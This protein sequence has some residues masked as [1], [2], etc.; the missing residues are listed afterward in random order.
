MQ[1]INIILNLPSK[2]EMSAIKLRNFFKSENGNNNLQR[3]VQH[4]LNVAKDKMCVHI[5]LNI[6]NV[7]EY[8]VIQQFSNISPRNGKYD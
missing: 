8:P 7:I 3:I 2:R 5:F 1:N 4:F 6:N